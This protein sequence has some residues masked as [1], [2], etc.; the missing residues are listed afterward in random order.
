MLGDAHITT[1]QGKSSARNVFFKEKANINIC[2]GKKLHRYCQ[3]DLRGKK[4]QKKLNKRT[5][6]IKF[7]AE[8]KTELF[9]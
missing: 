5:E 2:K 1:H 4:K 7:K 6:W 8:M 9:R 3:L